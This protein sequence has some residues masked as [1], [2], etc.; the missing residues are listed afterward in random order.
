MEEIF[1]LIALKGKLKLDGDLQ[2]ILSTSTLES[3]RL[4]LRVNIYFYV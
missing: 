2:Q 4:R 1:A 3:E